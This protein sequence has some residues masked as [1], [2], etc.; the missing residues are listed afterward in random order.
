[1]KKTTKDDKKWDDKFAKTQ[2]ELSKMAKEALKEHKLGK[3]K[4]CR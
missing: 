3:T 1:M 2:K 4:P